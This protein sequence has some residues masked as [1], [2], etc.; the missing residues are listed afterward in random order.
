MEIEHVDGKF[1][2]ITPGGEAFLLYRVDGNV[3]DIYETF[4]PVKERGHGIASQLTD[5]ALKF[6]KSKGFEVK[7]TCSYV[8]HKEEGK[9]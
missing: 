6:A 3:M 7:L 5:E 1:Y 4:V 9:A 2:T 8:R